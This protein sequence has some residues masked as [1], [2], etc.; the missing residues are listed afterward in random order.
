LAYLLAGLAVGRLALRAAAY[1][2]AAAR[3]RRREQPQQPRTASALLLGP[4]GGYD[5]LRDVVDP[6]TGTVQAVVGAGASATSP[7]RRGG[8]SPRMRRTAARLST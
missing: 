8:G 1:G 5:R 7:R 2:P 3:H 4:L 6:V